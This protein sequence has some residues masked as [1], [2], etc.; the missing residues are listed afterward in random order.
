VPVR[1]APWFVSGAAPPDRRRPVQREVQRLS[2]VGRTCARSLRA[3]PLDDVED[4]EDFRSVPYHL[5]VARL[6]PP[7]DAVTIDDERR[8]IRNVPLIVVHAVGADDL[9]VHITEKRKAE[10][11]GADEGIVAERAVAADREHG[12][13]AS[14][15]FG[16]DLIQAAEL[17]RSDAAEVVTIKYEHH[18][19]LA[20]ELGE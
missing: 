16:R 4:P 3:K 13:A 5:T 12:G 18:V 6:T 7:Q 8:A 17:R 14:L 9:A 1:S 10:A 20:F 15:C 2:V 11:A 19:G